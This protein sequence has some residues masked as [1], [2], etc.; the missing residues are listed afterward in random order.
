MNENLRDPLLNALSRLPA[1]APDSTRAD[2][3]R[4][5]CRQAMR[6]GAPLPTDRG[7]MQPLAVAAFAVLYA[8][9]VLHTVLRAYGVI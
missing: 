3:V 1:Q 4:A 9:T 7:M 8:A 2:R 6:D 5:R